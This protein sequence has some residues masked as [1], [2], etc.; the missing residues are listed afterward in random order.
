[1]NL[2]TAIKSSTACLQR[3]SLLISSQ[4][5]SSS[6]SVTVAARVTLRGQSG[7][8]TCSPVGLDLSLARMK[9]NRVESNHCGLTDFS[10]SGMKES[11][12]RGRETLYSTGISWDWRTIMHPVHL[13][14]KWYFTCSNGF[15]SFLIM[16]LALMSPRNLMRASTWHSLMCLRGLFLEL[17]SSPI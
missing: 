12:S 7:W 13:K 4:N 3:M 6:S 2:F 16:I 11:L 1:M 17:T 9:E 14:I 5:T 8:P 15:W 10:R